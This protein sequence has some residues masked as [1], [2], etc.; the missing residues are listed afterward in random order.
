[1]HHYSKNPTVLPVHNCIQ[2][3][4]FFI[5]KQEERIKWQFHPPADVL[6]YN[7]V[8]RRQ[9]V[10]PYVENVHFHPICHVLPKAY[11]D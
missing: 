2:L 7:G 11:L 4:S 9:G 5:K 1:M 8:T 6:A 3:T 10:S